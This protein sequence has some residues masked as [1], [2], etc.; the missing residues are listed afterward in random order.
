MEKELQ[1]NE[2][3][4]KFTSLQKRQ[5]WKKEKVQERTLTILRDWGVHSPVFFKMNLTVV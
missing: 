4:T 5:N 2:S 3:A 1:Q